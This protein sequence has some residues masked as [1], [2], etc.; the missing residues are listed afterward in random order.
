MEIN[1]SGTKILI[2]G[3]ELP[4]PARSPLKYGSRYFVPCLTNFTGYITE[5]WE[6]LDID[7]HRLSCGVVHLTKE[8][9]VSHTK[10]M[11]SCTKEK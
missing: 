10:A 1:N 9:A 5:A 7:W 2:N 11:L 8:A 4:G 6:D 3:Y